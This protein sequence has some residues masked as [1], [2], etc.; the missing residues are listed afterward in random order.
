M[1]LADE[2]HLVAIGDVPMDEEE[3]EMAKYEFRF[4]VTDVELSEEVQER[5]G[6]VVAQA[7]ASA[8]AEHTPPDAIAI[9]LRRNILWNGIP[10]VVE[11]EAL[12]AAVE[13]QVGER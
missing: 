3:S 11:F 9:R 1:L 4:I 12:Q 13:A 5:I 7:G 10:P 8:L 6:R 2:Q